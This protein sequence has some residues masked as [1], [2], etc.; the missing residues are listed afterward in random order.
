M[1]KKT[2]I[3]AP[4]VYI[5]RMDRDALLLDLAQPQKD[6]QYVLIK[7]GA[8]LFSAILMGQE[9][10][11]IVASLA[12][13]YGFPT[14]TIEQSIDSCFRAGWII[15]NQASSPQCVHEKKLWWLRWLPLRLEAIILLRH[16]HL[17]IQHNAFL[18]LVQSLMALPAEQDWE[19]DSRVPKIIQRVNEVARLFQEP[20]TCLH[21]SLAVC[22]MLRM[23]GI[24]AQVAIRVQQDPLMG[25]MIVV[26]G[27]HVISWK[28]G[29]HSITTCAHFLA[30]TTL[31]FHS[32]QLDQHYR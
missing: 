8:L 20:M 30:A 22:W 32:G 9:R 13:M 31:L 12:N 19:Q 18:T 4:S 15:E 25:H 23:R 16:I 5:A 29:L 24:A 3:L 17:C 6:Q 2:Y 10:S 1:D 21:Q 28:P 11:S 27:E 26:N 7:G 14:K